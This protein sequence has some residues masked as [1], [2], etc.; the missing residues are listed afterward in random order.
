MTIDQV[1]QMIDSCDNLRDRV[2]IQ[3]LFVTGMR[4]S[5]MV[6][7]TKG[8]NPVLGL[9]TDNVIW[10]ENVL[11]IRHAKRK[12]NPPRRINV[13]AGTLQLLREYL[14]KR[15]EKSDDAGRSADGLQHRQGSRRAGWN[16]GSRRPSGI[17][18][19]APTPASPQA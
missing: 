14:E 19:A 18:E 4:V 1:R 17:Q 2:L 11:V 5:E 8:S 3:I 9:R 7:P 16:N 15:P 12:D 10:E 13:D 6:K